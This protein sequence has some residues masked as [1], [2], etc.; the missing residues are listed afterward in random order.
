MSDTYESA[1]TLLKPEEVNYDPA[2]FG[3]L[4]DGYLF[5][6]FKN[7]RLKKKLG[8]GGMGQTWLAEELVENEVSQRV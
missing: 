7:Y 5:G 3:E 4:C 6:K 1:L 8:E 2:Q